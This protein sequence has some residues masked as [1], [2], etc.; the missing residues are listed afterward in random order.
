MQCPALTLVAQLSSIPLCAVAP[1]GTVNIDALCSIFARTAGTFVHIWKIYI[2][3]DILLD[4]HFSFTI[5]SSYD[6]H[7]WRPL[8]S[9]CSPTIS[10]LLSQTFN[11]ANAWFLGVSV[12]ITQNTSQCFQ[13]KIWRL[14]LQLSASERLDTEMNVGMLYW[15]IWNESSERPIS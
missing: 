2:E 5:H 4:H 14:F 8:I 6:F 13:R 3:H 12:G 10:I 9:F 15:T 11:R 7:F 1:K